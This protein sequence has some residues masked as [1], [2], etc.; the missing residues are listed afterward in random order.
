M[1]LTAERPLRLKS[2]QGEPRCVVERLAQT[3]WTHRVSLYI[4]LVTTLTLLV[5]LFGR[6]AWLPGTP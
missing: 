1:I 6:P 3:A 4:A 2:E 5:M